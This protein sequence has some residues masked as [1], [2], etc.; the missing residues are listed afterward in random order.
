MTLPRFF[1]QVKLSIGQ[2]TP[3]SDDIAHYVRH[4]LRLERGAEVIVFNGSGGEYRSRLEDVSKKAIT[5]TPE[6]FIDTDR[7]GALSVHLGLC[8]LKRDAMDNA[9][10]R[11]VE[12]GA[13]TITPIISE[14]VA[15]A[16]KVIARRGEHWQKVVYSA[17]EQ[18]G[19]NL[20][21]RVE[22]PT[23][24]SAWLQARNEETRLVASIGAPPLPHSSK[25]D[26]RIALLIG[27]EGGL[28]GAEVNHAFEL[29]FTGLG[30]GERIL[31]AETVPLVTLSVL[32][33][34]WG[35]YSPDNY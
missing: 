18:C 22:T 29:G 21:P 34:A 7:A 16:S 11:A 27:P 20:V 24:L 25:P 30:L 15:V 13:T 19:L 17:C 3:L 23:E 12:L 4:V 32:H 8:V 5:V 28:T 14:H 31:R 2:P 33:R 1:V 35:D 9:I 26:G 6:Q 10:G